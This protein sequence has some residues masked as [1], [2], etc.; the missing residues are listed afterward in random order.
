MG[1]GDEIMAAGQARLAR[2]RDAE[3][4][5]VRIVDGLRRTRTHPIWGGNDDIPRLGE[6]GDFLTVL[7][8]PGARPYIAEK[9]ADRWVWKDWAD[10]A[11]PLGKIVLS[12]DERNWARTA[13]ARVI[14]EP[15]VK[16]KA[17]PNKN[18]G[19]T[20]WNRLAWILQERHGVRVTQLGGLD[21]PFLEG[22][23]LVR[24][25]SFRQA[26]AV[27]ATAR[28]CVLPEGGLHHAAAALGVPAVVIFGGFIAPRH[29]GYAA[30]VNL[31]TGGEACGMRLPCDHCREAMAKISPEAVAEHLMEYLRVP[32]PAHLAA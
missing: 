2:E 25:D 21:T 31:F 19:W 14:L 11:P 15:T 10:G 18:W 16:A 27:L 9:H 8:A 22:A 3:H 23:E 29:T 4:R 30:H 24:T 32:A 1:W 28:A 13:G 12:Q 7:N 26:C 20:R 17:S 6:K 5:R